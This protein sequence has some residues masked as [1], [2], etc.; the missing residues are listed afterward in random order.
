MPESACQFAMNLLFCDS[1][2]GIVQLV[3]S[4]S[5]AMIADTCVRTAFPD[6]ARALYLYFLIN[7][8]LDGKHKYIC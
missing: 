3:V 4:L 2:C 8:A 5:H 6:M 1:V 7:G